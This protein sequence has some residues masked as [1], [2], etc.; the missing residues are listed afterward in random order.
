MIKTAGELI[1]TAQLEIN[2]DVVYFVV[3]CTLRQ[4]NFKRKYKMEEEEK[5]EKNQLFGNIII[6]LLHKSNLYKK[7]KK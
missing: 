7:Q 4:P 1:A 6:S 3:Q 5:K 2:C